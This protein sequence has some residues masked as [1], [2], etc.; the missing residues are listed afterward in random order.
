MRNIKR[1][2]AVF[3]SILLI[4]P[5]IFAVLPQTTEEVQA[6]TTYYLSTTVGYMVTTDQDR[7]TYLYTM[8]GTK[9]H[10]GDFVEATKTAGSGGYSVPL[11]RVSGISGVKYQSSNTKAAVV[12]SKSG[13]VT[14]KA[15]GT[16]TI[17]M[18]FNGAECKINVTVLKK[19]TYSMNS[20]AKKIE[21]AAKKLS[22]DVNKKVTSQNAFAL[23]KKVN[24]Y[25]Q[26]VE[27]YRDKSNVSAANYSVLNDFS[28]AR[29]KQV[30][31]SGEI[32][33][34]A[35]LQFK[36]REFAKKTSG[37]S[38]NSA[39]N[40]KVKSV[41]ATPTKITYRLKKKATKTQVLGAKCA[42]AYN[43]TK[44]AG[45]AGVAYAAVGICW[46]NQWIYGTA[47][48][49]AGSDIVTVTD[50][51]IWNTKTYQYEKRKLKRGRTYQVGN[52]F[53]WNGLRN[54]KVK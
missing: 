27:K 51:K 28:G 2:V 21:N 14:P 12:D 23:S 46:Q 30:I 49:K 24:A 53:Y 16:A 43:S 39:V 26:V 6:K 50:F 47:K 32:A 25:N 20:A 8:V 40:V 41:S 15:T 54:V 7:T 52:K 34:V 31:M 11:G 48:L 17:K 42:C 3:L 19:N 35:R 38:T 45:N 18:K 29:V 37:F 5:S 9:F 1:R 10:I 33:S 22:K 13:L 44:D 36:L 4:L